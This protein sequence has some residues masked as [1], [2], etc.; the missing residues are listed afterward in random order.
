MASWTFY[1]LKCCDGSLYCGRTIDLDRRLGQHRRGKGSKYVRLRLPCE[2]EVAMG[3]LTYK[4]AD[5]LERKMKAM[6]RSEKLLFIERLKVI[7]RLKA[8]VKMLRDQDAW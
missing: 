8:A 7:K 2:V 6:K 1:V 3:G 5:K 4:Y